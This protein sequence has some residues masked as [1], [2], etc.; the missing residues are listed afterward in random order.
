[1][2]TMDQLDEIRRFAGPASTV[3]L[4]DSVISRFLESDPALAHV[5]AD[6]VREHRAMREAFGAELAGSEDDLVA[7]LQSA[8]TNFYPPANV[9]PYV[10]LAAKGP[11]IVTSHGAVLHDN[12]GYG[13]LGMGH[14]PAA[15]IDAMTRP[16]VMANVMT[17]SF[18]HERFAARLRREV[19]QNR[20]EGCPF[21]KFVCMNSGSEAVTVAARIAD[22]NTLAQ[23]GKGGPKE[24]WTVN[25]LSLEGSFHGRT[26][27]PAQAS[28]SSLPTYRKQLASFR[29]RDNLITVPPNDV[30]ALREA[31]AEAERD[32]VFIEMV[33]LEPVMGEG[34][35]GMALDRAFYDAARELTLRH[36]SMLLI[37]SIQTIDGRT[38]DSC[39]QD[40]TAAMSL[41]RPEISSGGRSSVSP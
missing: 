1:M 15:I 40:S 17:P 29:K 28:D 3:G 7:Q 41:T 16:Y 24:G 18:T 27:R 31:F 8:Y 10:P 22:H 34:N 9:N 37:D 25:Y 38:T 2:N 21:H 13:M 14:A 36:G 39:S 20:P 19:G 6:A 4:E 12:G 30:E 32:R 5:I 26:D 33:F 35:P 23:T 11:W